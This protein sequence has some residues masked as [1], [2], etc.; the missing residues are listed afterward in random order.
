[1]EGLYHQ[2]YPPDT[3]QGAFQQFG[4][5]F[6]AL[7]NMENKQPQAQIAGSSEP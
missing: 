5:Y 2:Q 1:M 4:N 6:D 3:K 7:S